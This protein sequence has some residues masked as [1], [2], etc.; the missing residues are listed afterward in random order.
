MV[1]GQDELVVGGF[2][3][4]AWRRLV[5]EDPWGCKVWLLNANLLTSVLVMRRARRRLESDWVATQLTCGV[6]FVRVELLLRPLARS[7]LPEKRYTLQKSFLT[8]MTFMF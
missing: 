1:T 7:T 6:L 3:Y 2:S 8:F 5:V 4:D